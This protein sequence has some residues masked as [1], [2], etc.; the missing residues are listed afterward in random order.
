TCALQYWKW[1]EKDRDAA[2]SSYLSI[3]DVGGSKPFL[4]IVETGSL[5]SP[6]SDGCL[7]DIVD[8]SYSVLRDR[9]PDFMMG[10]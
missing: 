3:C 8:Y 2:F 7:R 10:N 6:F 9:H 4:G 5:T 1:S